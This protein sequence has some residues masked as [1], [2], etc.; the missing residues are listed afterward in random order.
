MFQQL[1]IIK[2]MNLQRVQKQDMNDHHRNMNKRLRLLTK[3]KVYIEKR[4]II[5]LYDEG[6]G[7]NPQEYI[8]GHDGGI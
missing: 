1:K 6:K 3:R 5:D 2:G 7:N 4:D 8:P